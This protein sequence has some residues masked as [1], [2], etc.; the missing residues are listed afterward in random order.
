VAEGVR[1]VL[2]DQKS[3]YL[4]GYQP[5][6]ATFDQTTGAPRFH[7]LSVRV[8]R[9]GLSVRTRNGFYGIP[10]E[11]ARPTRRTRG[12]QLYGAITSPFSSGELRVR[13]TSLFANDAV[14]GSFMRSLLHIDAGNLTFAKEADGTYSAGIDVLAVTFG[15]AGQVINEVNRTDTVRV[16]AKN[17]EALVRYGFDYIVNVPVVKP[18]AYQLRLAVRDVASERVGS[19]SQF[20]EVPNLGDNR[21]A[22]S[23]IVLS[24]D[25]LPAAPKEGANTP[26][27]FTGALLGASPEQK[28]GAPSATAPA[29]QPDAHAGPATRRLRR[30]AELF[31]NFAVYNARSKGAGAQPQLSSQVRLFR[32]GRQLFAGKTMPIEIGEQRDMKRL[33]AGG[34]MKLG[35]GAV[36]GEYVLQIVVTDTSPGER[37]RVASQWIDFE[38]VE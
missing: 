22:L 15:D 23:G 26:G 17:Y 18:G 31:Y 27:P 14:A 19:A 7:E 9:P 10:E 29:S 12:E 35:A 33:L 5:D 4:I 6:A 20:I 36:P 30:G 1:A 34:R 32:D 16:E 3:F 13:L 38:I 11:A 21:L 24:G 8:K 37:P 2:Q 28:A 25:D